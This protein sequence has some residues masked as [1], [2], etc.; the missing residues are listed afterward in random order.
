ML[1]DLPPGE[2]ARQGVAQTPA[3]GTLA[4]PY[5]KPGAMPA[6]AEKLLRAALRSYYAPGATQEVKDANGI[7]IEEIAR[8]YEIPDG[9]VRVVAQQVR[10]EMQQ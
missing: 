9:Q 7:M 5:S 1:K 2:L 8:Q 3:K 6:A 4:N 10:A